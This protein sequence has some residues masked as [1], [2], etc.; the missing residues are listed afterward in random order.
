ML[1]IIFKFQL[2]K[3][4]RLHF[5]NLQL[6][7]QDFDNLDKIPKGEI[8]KRA[9]TFLVQALFHKKI[10]CLMKYKMSG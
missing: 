7:L 3:D 5:M 2:T 6:I 4:A 10:L 1:Y 8:A 9:L